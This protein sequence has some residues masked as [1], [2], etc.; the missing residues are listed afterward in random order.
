MTNAERQRKW[1]AKNRALHNLRRRNKRKNLPVPVLAEPQVYDK[2]GKLKSGQDYPS[3]HCEGSS[4]EARE[5]TPVVRGA[6]ETS[7]AS[8]SRGGQLPFE[9][10]KVGEFRM[11]VLPEQPKDE[12]VVPV[13]K[14]Q[15]FRNDYGAVISE[16][17]WKRLQKLKQ[18]A[19]EGGYELDEYSQ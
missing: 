6:A 4:G 7:K 11:L 10:K 5:S 14:P 12:P 19:K 1:I 2:I 17:A 9:T 8:D 13:V 15:V 16:S 3:Q 18:E